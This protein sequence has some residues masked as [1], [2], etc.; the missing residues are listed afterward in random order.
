MRRSR[1]MSF[2]GAGALIIALFVDALGTGL[3]LPFSLLYFNV[4]AGLP[5]SDVGVVLTLATFISLPVAILS[6]RVMDRIGTLRTIVFSQVLQALGFCGYLFV[7]SIP[8]LLVMALL[9]MGGLRI[10]WVALPTFIAEM[11]EGGEQDRWFGLMGTCQN[12]GFGF[13]GLVAGVLIAVGQQVGYQVIVIANACS[14]LLAAAL[15]LRMQRNMSHRPQIERVEQ[16]VSYRL[17]FRDRP[18]LIMVLCNIAFV[19]CITLFAQAL[20]VYVIEALH[21]PVWIAG[22][23]FAT[24]TAMLTGLQL[25]TVKLIEPLRR[26][27]ILMLAGLIWSAASCLFILALRIPA[28]W[29]IPYMFLAAILYTVGELLY[30]PTANTLMAV[31]GPPELKGRYIAVYEFIS[32]GIGSAITPAMFTFLFGFGP[33]SPWLALIGL[34]LGATF[35]V[36]LVEARLPARAIRK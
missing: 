35:V 12:A 33:A 8:L 6:G 4:V 24:S 25:L 16:E 17:V 32:W 15:L 34:T 23:L 3:F 10:F 22:A 9:V 21:A 2:H 18:F 29:L 14:F 27:R 26:T 11:A 13:G 5:L 1:T 19:L 36:F 7:H 30:I 28:V 31:I 20:P